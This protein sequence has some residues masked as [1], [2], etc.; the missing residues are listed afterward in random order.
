MAHHNYILIVG[1]GRLGSSLANRLSGLGHSVFVVDRDESAFDK[2]SIEFSGFRITGD[3]AEMET[4]QQ[5]RIQQASCVLVTTRRDSVNL[6][7]SQVAKTIFGVPKVVARV[8]DPARET[9]YQQFGIETI[10]PT[11]LTVDSFLNR[12]Q[13]LVEKDPS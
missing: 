5:A 13:P 8:F 3:A 7:V 10:C 4:L 6:M 9:V 11:A 12:L 1:C 2:L